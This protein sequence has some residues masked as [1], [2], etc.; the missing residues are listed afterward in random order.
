MIQSKKHLNIRK[1]PV[2]NNLKEKNASD[3]WWDDLTWLLAYTLNKKN[4]KIDNYSNGFNN[5]KQMITNPGEREDIE[6]HI[7]NGDIGTWDE[8]RIDASNWVKAL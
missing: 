8:K 5:Q 4:K 2:T 7:C 1:F 6:D 3:S